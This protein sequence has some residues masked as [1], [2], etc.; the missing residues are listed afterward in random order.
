[1]RKTWEMVIATF[2]IVMLIPVAFVL[3]V[4]ISSW[5]SQWLGGETENLG[6]RIV[7]IK[8]LDGI[9]KEKINSGTLYVMD[10]DYNILET[11][12][13]SDGKAYTENEYRYKSRLILFADSK[14]YYFR[15]TEVKLIKTSGDYYTVTYYGYRVPSD[16]EISLSL[17]DSF[18][19]TVLSE[20]KSATFSLV[21]SSLSLIIHIVL[22]PKVALI[23]YYDPLEKEDDQVIVWLFFNNTDVRLDS[24][25]RIEYGSQVLYAFVVDERIS[26]VTESISLDISVTLL[27]TGT[28]T[29]AVRLYICDRTD[30]DFFKSAI[31]PDFQ[32][33]TLYDYTLAGFIKR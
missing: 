30:L 7:E 29:I 8:V 1:M 10:G 27:Y 12:V 9:T 32:D 2:F 24:G 18:G 11:L 20:D 13:I 28:G 6:E 23:S 14:E 21:D 5:I 33:N 4:Y 31:T 3:G 25:T 17:T 15:P 22:Y 19:T 26:S 16:A